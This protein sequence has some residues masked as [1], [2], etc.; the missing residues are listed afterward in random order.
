MAPGTPLV[1]L[2]VYIRLVIPPFSVIPAMFQGGGDG[3]VR[4]LRLG[5]GSFEEKGFFPA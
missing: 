3:G 2:G 5:P 4:V 1:L